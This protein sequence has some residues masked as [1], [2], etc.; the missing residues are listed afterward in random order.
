M[1]AFGHNAKLKSLLHVFIKNSLKPL[2]DL[3]SDNFFVLDRCHLGLLPHLTAD[4]PS[5]AFSE[6]SGPILWMELVG[7]SSAS[8]M[9][10]ILC[11]PSVIVC[12]SAFRFA[13]ES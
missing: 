2:E 4:V 6:C 3:R 11:L 13:S 8:C 7:G 5:V 10:F 12:S 1:S 9:A